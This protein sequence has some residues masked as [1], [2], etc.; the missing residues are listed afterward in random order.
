MKRVWGGVLL[1]AIAAI[2][3]FNIK[4]NVR[5]HQV[6]STLEQQGIPDMY[7]NLNEQ[8]RMGHPLYELF[9]HQPYE[10]HIRDTQDKMY[11]YTYNSYEGPDRALEELEEKAEYLKSVSYKAYRKKNILILYVF[12]EGQ[13][14]DIIDHKITNTMTQI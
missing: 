7:K 2:V 4:T 1:V 9:G 8:V 13:M 5:L 12:P 11:I 10:V 6:I 14:S 3:I